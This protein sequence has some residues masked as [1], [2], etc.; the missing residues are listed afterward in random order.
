MPGIKAFRQ[1]TLSELTHV[2]HYQKCFGVAKGTG[3]SILVRLLPGVRGRCVK[4][5][6]PG[7]AARV[8]VRL[9][10]TDIDVFNSTFADE[11]YGIAL[12]FSPDTIVDA[13]A[14]TGLSSVYLAIRYPGAR[15]IA[16][17]PSSSNFELLASNTEQFP[18]VEAV[19]VALWASPGE[20]TLRDPGAGAWA[21]RVDGEQAR[22]GESQPRGSELVHATTMSEILSDFDL[23]RVNLL[24]ID[25]EGSE[26]EIFNDSEKWLEHV[27]AI[28]VE[29]HDRFKPGCARAFL[30]AVQDF[31]VEVWRG[32]VT[33]VARRGVGS[34]ADYA[35]AISGSARALV[36]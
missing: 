13:G 15:I 17:E 3:L 8:S 9:G 31:P 12:P 4:V 1:W 28:M 19:R 21:F 10:S 18:N 33:M 26:L 20:L 5:R 6:V 35:K 7:C 2:Y 29:L 24:K 36:G 25:V 27:D 23:G 22:P 14:Y 16:L 30:S 34:K 32:E 11:D